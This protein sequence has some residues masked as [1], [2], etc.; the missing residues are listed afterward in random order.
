MLATQMVDST[1]MHRWIARLAFAGPCP[2]PRPCHQQGL[3]P[4]SLADSTIH[5]PRKRH[6]A[7]ES[8]I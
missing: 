2:R 7:V 3:R 4:A 6:I 8:T 1:A 5:T